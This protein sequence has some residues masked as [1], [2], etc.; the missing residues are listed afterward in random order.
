MGEQ[1]IVR[2]VTTRPPEDSTTPFVVATVE[3]DQI[4]E[5]FEI[6]CDGEVWRERDSGVAH[7]PFASYEAVF[8]SAVE[9]ALAHARAYA[10]P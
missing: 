5:R 1:I 9:T 7:G 4:E 8:T 2:I 3:H 6:W 10:Y